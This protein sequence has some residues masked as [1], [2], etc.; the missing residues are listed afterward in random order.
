MEFFNQKQEVIDVVMT[1]HGKQ[2]Y[3]KGKF[4]PTFYAFFDDDI[5]YDGD[6]GGIGESQDDIEG[7]IQT[8]P[9]IK[10]IHNKAG[11]EEQINKIN[12]IARSPKGKDLIDLESLDKLQHEKD[13]DYS[14][15][16]P[17]MSGADPYSD[18][19]PSWEINFLQAKATGSISQVMEITSSDGATKQFE[20]IPQ[21]EVVGNL[22]T[23]LVYDREL[24]HDQ[25]YVDDSLSHD[26]FLLKRDYIILEVFEN[27]T[28]YL[29]TNFDFEIYKIEDVFSSS[30]GKNEKEKLVKLQ[31]APV[32][33]NGIDDEVDIRELASYSKD[34]RYVESYL[35]VT[36][37]E[38][39][40]QEIICEY[41]SD[42]RRGVFSDSMLCEDQG[43]VVREQEV[44]DVYGGLMDTNPGEP[45]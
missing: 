29:L 13:R 3:A 7:R 34:D 23:W 39:I 42:R 44:Y 9:R 6:Y 22:E 38:E 31:F 16:H 45:C 26:D 25:D 35:H 20:P 8:S 14:L 2:L 17:L 28:E 33:A 32:A 37:D 21:I 27:N 36:A 12:N 40:P 19:Y 24:D 11:L 10:T 1:Q 15:K 5:L 43:S 18:N 4:K 30:T 41:I